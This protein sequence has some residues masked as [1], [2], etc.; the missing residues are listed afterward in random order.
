[1]TD[2]L[3]IGEAENYH[4]KSI[5]NGDEWLE[6]PTTAV[7]PA[8]VTFENASGGLFMQVQPDNGPSAATFSGAAVGAAID[9]KIQINTPGTYRLYLRWDGHNNDSD[10]LYAGILELVDG[11]GG[12]HAD[13]YEDNIASTSDFALQNWN[14]TG[15]AEVNVANTAQNPMTWTISAGDITAN[16][17]LFTLRIVGREDGVAL[18]RWRL[19]LDSL[20]DPNPVP[21]TGLNVLI[22]QDEFDYADGDL[23]GR[24][25]GTNW[26]F[27]NTTNNGAF[28]GFRRE[29]GSTW[30]GIF[31]NNQVVSGSLQTLNS[32]AKREFSAPT[33]EHGA[34][35]DW[36]SSPHKQ[37]YFRADDTGH[38]SR[39]AA[40]APMTLAPSVS[41]SECRAPWGH[42]GSISSASSR[43][44]PLTHPYSQSRARP[45]RWWPSSTS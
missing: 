12:T 4:A 17:G 36:G 45:T 41:F 38:R 25:G 31:G 22:G 1:M 20:P 10:S 13:W 6:A 11:I 24:S 15:Q 23:V 39:G 5:G 30:D 37:V 9:Y 44:A 7:V 21:A 34:I 33:E 32:A 18:D 43:T 14:G 35:N 3:V 2:G 8:G 28:I 19:Q 40:S 29:G 42:P 27:D 26:D 16:G